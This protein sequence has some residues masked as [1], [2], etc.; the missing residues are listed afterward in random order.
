LGMAGVQ[1]GIVRRPLPLAPLRE[2]LATVQRAELP[3]GR[4]ASTG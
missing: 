4:T 1:R 2:A 3:A